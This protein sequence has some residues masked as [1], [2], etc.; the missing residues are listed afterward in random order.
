MNNRLFERKAEP[1]LDPETRETLPMSSGTREF[2]DSNGQRIDQL[3]G[4]V[5]HLRACIRQ[6]L[7]MIE[8]QSDPTDEMTLLAERAG[9]AER[10]MLRVE[11]DVADLLRTSRR[12]AEDR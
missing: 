4:E 1:G 8:G 5:D 6:L 12:R 9:F 7:D 11:D 3:E 2:V 10:R